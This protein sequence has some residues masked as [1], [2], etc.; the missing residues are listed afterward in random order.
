MSETTTKATHT[1]GPWNIDTVDENAAEGAAYALTT[2]VESQAGDCHIA[3]VFNDKP[4]DA[5]LICA[6]PDLLAACKRML[7]IFPMGPLDMAAKFGPDADPDT[8][9]A[10]ACEM[11][12]KAIQKAT[13]A[14]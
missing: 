5:L 6:A 8:L 4:A 3:F 2:V 9:Y 7:E 13:G 12:D 10:Q 11:A 1:E 14:T